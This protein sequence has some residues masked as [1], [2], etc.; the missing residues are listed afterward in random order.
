MKQEKID[1]T[2]PAGE[3]NSDIS[4]SKLNEKIGNVGR[5]DEENF[6]SVFK[7]NDHNYMGDMIRRWESN[8]YI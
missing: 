2:K 1:N 7:S 6:P 5:N 4:G 3:S 8:Q